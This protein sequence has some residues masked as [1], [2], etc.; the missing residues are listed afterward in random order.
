MCP[1]VFSPLVPVPLQNSRTLSSTSLPIHLIFAV[2]L[3][4]REEEFDSKRAYD[5]FL[6]QREEIIANLV[7]GTD[8]AKTESQLAEYA[9]ANAQSI[10]HNKALASQESAAFIEFQIRRGDSQ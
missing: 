6:E 3:N 1:L 10:R 4:R 8:V 5:D 9:A 2:S 7:Y